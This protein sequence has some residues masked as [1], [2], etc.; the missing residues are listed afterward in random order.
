MTDSSVLKSIF[1]HPAG[2]RVKDTESRETEK[3]TS[4]EISFPKRRNTVFYIARD[5]IW[6]LGHWKDDTLRDFLDEINPDLIYLPIYHSPYMNE[7]QQY[8]IK[9]CKVPYCIHISDD[10]ASGPPS[11]A[12]SPLK[13][14][15]HQITYKMIKNTCKGASYGEAFAENMVREYPSL[16][17]IPFFLIGKGVDTS[18]IS[19]N[20]S[21]RIN[22]K[23]T[24]VY[25]GNYGGERGYQL[26]NF[27]NAAQRQF[28]DKGIDA[29]LNIYSNTMAE[30]NIQRQL[31]KYPFVHLCGGVSALEVKRVQVQADYL[32]H[33]EGFSKES[34]VS[35]KMSFST[36]LIDY[37]LASKPIVA[38]GS[39]EINSIEVLANHQLAYIANDLDSLEKVLATISVGNED[40]EKAMLSR[41]STYL[42]T[43]RDRNVIQKGILSRLEMLY[44]NGS[45]SDN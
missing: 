5:L 21:Q 27:V 10:I 20:I 2:R 39:A 16:F 43:N 44:V 33:V 36:K 15:Y 26:V 32:L 31:Q 3:Q 1:G 23:I 11:A 13:S 38:I 17:N 7:V 18:T 24:F 14:L 30:K 45:I 8:I 19:E 40:E 4:N 41:V 9:Y 12:K 35:T 25:T 28:I 22:S 34:I 42:K 37:M 29:E 6:K